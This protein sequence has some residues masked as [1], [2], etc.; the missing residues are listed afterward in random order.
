MK[1]L[2]LSSIMAAL[3]GTAF[4]QSPAPSYTNTP[5]NSVPGQPGQPAELYQGTNPAGGDHTKSTMTIPDPSGINNGGNNSYYPVNPQP[6]TPAA[7]DRGTITPGNTYPNPPGTPSP[8]GQVNWLFQDPAK[9]SKYPNSDPGTSHE[10]TRGKYRGNHKHANGHKFA[11]NH[12][13]I[14]KAKKSKSDNSEKSRN[15]NTR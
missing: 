1:K 12:R 9:T 2:I 6:A 5:S 10:G 3:C 14:K 15:E 11:K 13:H 4:T 7:G 8:T